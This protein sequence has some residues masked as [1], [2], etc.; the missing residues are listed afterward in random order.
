MAFDRPVHAAEAADGATAPAV[1]L[2][3]AQEASVRGDLAQ[4]PPRVYRFF[5]LGR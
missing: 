3:V 4:M 5:V 1:A 2:H